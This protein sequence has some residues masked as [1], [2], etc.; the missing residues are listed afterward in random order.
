MA[1]PSAP[2][3][4]GTAAAAGVNRTR[5]ARSGSACSSSAKARFKS[6]GR[7]PRDRSPES[8]PSD[9]SRFAA[10][11]AC[12]RMTSRSPWCFSSR[13]NCKTDTW[14]LILESMFITS[15][16]R[17][18]VAWPIRAKRAS[19]SRSVSTVCS[20]RPCR[21]DSTKTVSGLPRQQPRTSGEESGGRPTASSAPRPHDRRARR[22]PD[23]ASRRRRRARGKGG[24]RRRGRPAGGVPPARPRPPPGPRPPSAVRTA[25]AGGPSSVRAQALSAR[26]RDQLQER[27]G[28]RGRPF[29]G[30]EG[31]GRQRLGGADGGG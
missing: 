26:G 6:T 11:S 30:G 15:W 14:R 17:P 7:K 8:R 2:R 21:R 1:K 3:T 25:V 5:A 20:H 19:S 10:W 13:R 9:S 12:R 27:S 16:A 28:N 23:R 18:V 22:P 4:G 24:R 29:R 31:P